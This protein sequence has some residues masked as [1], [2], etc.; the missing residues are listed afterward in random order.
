MTLFHDDT[1]ATDGRICVLNLQLGTASAAMT[2]AMA[3]AG[4]EALSTTL[5]DPDIHVIVLTGSTQQF[6]LGVQEPTHEVQAAQQDEPAFIDALHDWLLALRDSDKPIV[7]AVEGQASGAG[8]ALALACD[9][10]VAAR[11]AQFLL[12]M[13][14]EIAG[15]HAGALWLAAQRLPRAALAELC[16]LDGGLSAER[17]HAL[18]LACRLTEPGM[19]LHM[20]LQLARPLAQHALMELGGV[21]QHMALVESRP[22]HEVLADERGRWLRHRALAPTPGRP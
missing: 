5:R 22:L 3:H 18:G 20:A 8:L 14:G 6:C 16:L 17:A 12:P 7:A 10:I 1:A 15:R 13:A 2:P 11:T 19:A 21:E 9:L 4:I